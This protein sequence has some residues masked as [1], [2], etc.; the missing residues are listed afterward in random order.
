MRRPTLYLAALA[1]GALLGGACL[2]EDLTLNAECIDGEDCASSQTCVATP[3]Q[4]Q[5]GLNGW[6]RPN[7]DCAPGEQ[8]GCVCDAAQCTSSFDGISLEAK[9]TCADLTGTALDTCREEPPT[10]GD[11]I[12]LIVQPDE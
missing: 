9:P 10:V 3:E 6:C 4:T 11:C 12:C 5:N 2:D 1:V 8:P 7:S